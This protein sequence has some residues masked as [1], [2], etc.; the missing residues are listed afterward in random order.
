MTTPARRIPSPLRRSPSRSPSPTGL[1]L[2]LLA[3]LGLA[4]TTN[5]SGGR[6]GGA[7]LFAAAAPSSSTALF[8][9][10]DAD[11]DGSISAQDWDASL[12]T[13]AAALGIDNA[14]I[15]NH[16]SGGELGARGRNEQA[17]AAQRPVHRDGLTGDNL[18]P[19]KAFNP[20][21]ASRNSGAGADGTGGNGGKREKLSFTRAFTA[22]VAMILATEIGDKTFFI[23]A[24]LSMRNDRAAV[25]AGAVLALVVM[26]VLR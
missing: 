11:A 23:A 14:D 4:W 15:S 1:S 5:N 18:V 17:A 8:E 20:A 10:L 22:S 2:L 13:I 25:F 9:A 16:V 26:T 3:F 6:R 19:R 21:S 7:A 24:V 12:S